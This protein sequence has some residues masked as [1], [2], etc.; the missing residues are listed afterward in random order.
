MPRTLKVDINPNVFKWLRVSS[1][2]SVEDASKKLKTSNEV[3]NSIEKGKRQPTLRQL[4]ELSKAY[5]RPLATF[6]LSEPLDEPSLPKDYRMIPDKKGVFD[7]KTIYAIRKARNLQ[8]IGGELL[9]NINNSVAP[10]I[11]QIK[12]SKK[13]DELGLYYRKYFNL[14]FEKQKKFNSSYAFFNYLRDNF[15]RINV[16][17]FQFSMPIEDARGFVLTDKNPNVI[18]VNSKDKIEARI[19]TLLH[20]FAH[21]LLGETVIDLPVL[22]FEKKNE[23]E[24]WCNHFA[25]SFLLPKTRAETL[26]KPEKSLTNK[27]TLNR[28]SRK[29]KVSKAMLLYTMYKQD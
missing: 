25:A 6:L 24:Y 21:I 8:E 23:I 27:T 12:S 20:E 18:V 17:V 7:K 9:I 3:I 5:K 29:Y 16:L 10:R 28:L 4:K 22:S 2:W 14:D 26:F 11:K 1:G 19:F 13:P 15:E